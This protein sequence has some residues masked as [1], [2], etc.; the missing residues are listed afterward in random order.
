MKRY[1]ITKKSGKK[2]RERKRSLFA[3]MVFHGSWYPDTVR[4]RPSS[5]H[6]NNGNAIIRT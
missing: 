1:L 3:I 5:P 4:R 6:N 2:M